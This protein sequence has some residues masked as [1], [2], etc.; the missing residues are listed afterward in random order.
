ME[1]NKGRCDFEDA[2]IN[3]NRSG[4][5]HGCMDGDARPE[6]KIEPG[7]EGNTRLDP[8]DNVGM[9][10]GH[11]GAVVLKGI[12]SWMKGWGRVMSVNICNPTQ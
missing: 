2:D 4:N 6:I 3:M 7:V 5:G 8:F 11:D 1:L 12:S 10:Y 9:L